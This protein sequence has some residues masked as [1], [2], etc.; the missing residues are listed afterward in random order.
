V[1]SRADFRT[2]T[3]TTE[4]LAATVV[5]ASA[6]A[7]SGPKPFRTDLLPDVGDLVGA[8]YR[9][10][11][12]LGKGMFGK[13]YVAER[14]DVPAHQVALKLVPRE[15]YSGRNV[16]RE[17]VMLAAA[18]HPNIVQLKDHGMT[19]GYVWLTMPVYEGVTL[20][21]RLKRGPLALDEAHEVFLPIARALDALHKA[22]LRHQ[23]IKPENI[24]LATFAGRLHPILLDLGVAAELEAPFV[25]GTMLYASPEQLS[26]LSKS[27]ETLPLSDKMDTYCLATTLLLSIVGPENFPGEGAQSRFEIAKAQEIRAIEPLAFSA[28]P[29][30][31]GAP[32]EAIALAF[33]RWMNRDPALRPPVGAMADELDV[34]LEPER[35]LDR[36]VARRALRQKFVRRVSLATTIAAVCIG[37]LFAY[38]K[39]ETLRLASELHQARAE[40]AASFDKLDTCIASHRLAQRESQACREARTKEEAEFRATLDRIAKTGGATDAAM[41]RQMQVLEA[42]LNTRIRTCE[43]DANTAARLRADE[44]E[45]LAGE[46]RKREA[47]LTQERDEQKKLAEAR[48]T[49]L[50]HCRAD[51]ETRSQTAQAALHPATNPGRPPTAPG[52]SASGSPGSGTPPGATVAPVGSAD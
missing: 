43:D 12:L 20:A 30:V 28:L 38:S 4:A 6:P 47:D 29:D 7:G 10:V 14:V 11:R 36:L 46:W 3:T 51:L 19:E 50:D 24:F 42:T 21:E 49:D 23:D 35:E 40:G 22:G 17:L 37:A 33:A 26:A 18:S 39:R 27:P 41:S 15:V 25:A 32:R 16:E 9:L 52:A 45:R 34:L 44:R 48:A 31:R 2:T 1:G 8:H 5:D 13:V